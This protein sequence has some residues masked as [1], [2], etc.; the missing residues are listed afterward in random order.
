L[1]R[2]TFVIG[3]RAGAA[4]VVAAAVSACAGGSTPT[5]SPAAA[6]APAT[7]PATTQASTG[8]PGAALAVN[9]SLAG[10]AITAPVEWIATVTG[11]TVADPVDHVDFLIDGTDTWTEHNVPYQFNDDGNLLMPSVLQPGAHDLAI[12]VTTK[13]GATASVRIGVTT[14]RQS[15]PD[16]LLG[17]VFARTV[18]GNPALPGGEWKFTLGVDGV[19]AFDDPNGSGGNEGFA[20]T[21]DGGM[22]LFGPANWVEP[23]DRQGGFCDDP[24]GIAM[25]QWQLDGTTLT[26]SDKNDPCPGRAF[27]F[28]AI[29]HVKA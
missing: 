6:T 1:D 28:N 11:V 16:A 4:L 18:P 9:S 14:T 27:L 13:S 2:T 22:S 23:V 29:W 21:S 7:A 24:E 15:V 12:E 10:G 20:A 17:K 26:L 5:P 3:T 25:L 8:E 19:L